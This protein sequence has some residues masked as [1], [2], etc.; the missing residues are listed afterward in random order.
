MPLRT[1]RLKSADLKEGAIEIFEMPKKDSVGIMDRRY[2]A[3]ID[4][5]DSDSGTSLGNIWIFDTFQQYFVAEYTGRPKF[6]DDFY[7]ICRRLLVF[8]NA[9][10]N[11]ENNL[12]GL[13]VY[14]T[15]KNCTHLLCDN[16]SFLVDKEMMKHGYGNTIKGTRATP[17]INSYA[18]R[19]IRDY[20]I[21][22]AAGIFQEFDSEGN[23]ITNRLNLH[24]IRSIPYL[25]ELIDWNIN[26]N[27]DRVS[28]AGMCL[29]LNEEY[30]K[31]NQIY[32]S[33]EEESNF[34]EDDYFN[35]YMTGSFSYGQGKQSEWLNF[36]IKN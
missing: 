22:E 36:N 12:K 14:F 18:R 23:Q 34:A 8:Y 32:T 13:Y 9:K 2:I 1:Y 31:F 35:Q 3:G 24:T 21:K 4:P 11:Y 5:I 25:E 10:A 20:L 33:K 27:Y 28:G 7:E 17:D 15:Q 6:A 26:G 29:I 16:P 19:L 30:K